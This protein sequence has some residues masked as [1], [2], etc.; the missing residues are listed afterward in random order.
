MMLAVASVSIIWGGNYFADLLPPTMG[1]L[2]WRKVMG[3]DFS[4]GELAWTSRQAAL[5]EFTKCPN[6]MVKGHPCE[7]PIELMT[8]C[9]GLVDEATTIVDP[10]AGVGTTGVAAKELGRKCILIE[11]EEVY[12]ERAA[13]RLEQEYLPLYAEDKV[14]ETKAQE[15]MKFD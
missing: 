8:W 4:D 7:K 14:I 15:E 6:G 10:F 11:R 3:G 5:R 1:W 9:I 12:C 13:K 2:Y